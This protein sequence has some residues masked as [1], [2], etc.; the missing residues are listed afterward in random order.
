MVSYQKISFNSWVW[1]KFLGIGS[2]INGRWW[3]KPLNEP[4]RANFN[5]YMATMGRGLFLFKSRGMIVT[6]F[7]FSTQFFLVLFITLLF[8]TWI[9]CSY[10]REA[11]EI[12]RSIWAE[13]SE[14][15]PCG[16]GRI[17]EKSDA[18]FCKTSI[19]SNEFKVNCPCSP[20]IP[21]D[22]PPTLDPYVNSKA[23]NT[24]N[25][26]VENVCDGMHSTIKINANFNAP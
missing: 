12:Y 22:N 11:G 10:K 3:C 13:A 25:V 26:L 4:R 14:R 17:R 20:L 7:W 18:G 8:T 1:N 21:N 19:E 24:A 15:H 16:L 9:S 6:A 5:N 23:I 2:R